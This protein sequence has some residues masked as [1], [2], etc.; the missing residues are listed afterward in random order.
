[1]RVKRKPRGNP[2]TSCI[3]QQDSHIIKSGSDPTYVVGEKS[4]HYTTTVASTKRIVLIFLSLRKKTNGWLALKRTV[5]GSGSINM[6]FL[7]TNFEIATTRWRSGNSLG[8]HSRGPG[9]DYRSCHPGY[10]FPWFP[11]VTPGECWDGF[12]T[13]AHS[14]P[15]SLF[16]A[17]LA[18]SLTTSLSTRL[19]A[20][21][22]IYRY[23]VLA[24]GARWLDYSPPTKA[25]SSRFPTGSRRDFRKWEPFWTM[26]LAGGFFGDLPLS[27]SPVILALL[28]T[29][30]LLFRPLPQPR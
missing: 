26:P 6:R 10:G 8:S 25:N 23:R 21:L 14:S 29:T 11:E 2:P 15:Q 22:S 19:Q 12:L 9:F 16:P 30:S 7:S 20:Q 28:H 18:P 17:L 13:K 24:A 27:P 1:M 5:L 4:N 3:V